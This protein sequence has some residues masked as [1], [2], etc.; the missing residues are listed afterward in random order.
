MADL[1]VCVAP[2]DVC[3]IAA[4]PEGALGAVPG[5]VEDAAGGIAAAPEGDGSYKMSVMG[6]PMCVLLCPFGI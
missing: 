6:L 5:V 4:A 1:V 3:G 2:V